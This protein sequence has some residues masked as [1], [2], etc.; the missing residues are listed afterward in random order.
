[1][2]AVLQR[3]SRASVTV[4]GEV[5]GLLS[6]PMQH[7]AV[8][9]RRDLRGM[10][11]RLEGVFRPETD[12]AGDDGRQVLGIP[13]GD[14]ECDSS[15]LH[16][17]QVVGPREARPGGW[18]DGTQQVAMASAAILECPVEE[19]RADRGGGP[20]G[21]RRREGRGGKQEGKALPVLA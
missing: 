10:G 19:P 1:M 15:A 8:P 6:P 20:R 12:L 3:V 21:P 13:C 16:S 14:P 9:G 4:E 7:D 18:P 17:R 11:P 5:V 2:R